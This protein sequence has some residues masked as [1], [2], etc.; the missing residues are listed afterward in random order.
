MQLFNVD[1]KGKSFE[2]VEK[3]MPNIRTTVPMLMS[4]DCFTTVY[5]REKML[6]LSPD[7]ENELL[8]YDPDDIY[9]LGA[10]VDKRESL[11][12]TLTK[13]RMLGMRHA[14]LP[15][16]KFVKFKRGSH[17]RLGI[18]N[19]VT[20]LQSWKNTKDWEEAL[21]KIPW[22]KLNDEEN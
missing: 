3:Y 19:V 12:L 1:F 5:R 11:P 10:V 15:L 7:S 18:N 22:Y 17:K 16:D 9:V 6:Y 14:R 8:T 2:M 4:E 21:K 20:I 13:A